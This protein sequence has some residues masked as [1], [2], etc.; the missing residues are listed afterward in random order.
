MLE[1]SSIA[2]SIHEQEELT[3]GCSSHDIHDDWTSQSV[4]P[5]YKIVPTCI[6]TCAMEAL[7]WQC[8]T[9]ILRLPWQCCTNI[10]HLPYCNKAPLPENAAYLLQPAV[11]PHPALTH[12]DLCDFRQI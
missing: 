1:S 12:H 2:I 4:W 6:D 10:L 5:V 7:P 11:H 9:N 3:L 8:C